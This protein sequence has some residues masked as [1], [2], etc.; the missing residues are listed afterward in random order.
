MIDEWNAYLDTH[1][2]ASAEDNIQID[3]ERRNV[4]QRSLKT[5]ANSVKNSGDHAAALDLEEVS[6][7]WEDIVWFGREVAGRKWSKHYSIAKDI[8]ES[9]NA[10]TAS[11]EDLRSASEVLNLRNERTNE[12]PDI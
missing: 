9:L 10:L 11:I 5:L 12:D 8:S 2:S 3:K 7:I 4:M 1:T 6:M